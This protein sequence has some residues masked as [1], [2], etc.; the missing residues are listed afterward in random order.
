[1]SLISWWKNKAWTVRI[2]LYTIIMM[3]ANLLEFLIS[4]FIRIYALIFKYLLW[5]IFD[6]IFKYRGEKNG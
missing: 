5:H 6:F 3:P 2:H 1:M 4:N